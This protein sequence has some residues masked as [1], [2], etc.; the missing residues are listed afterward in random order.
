MI[1]INGLEINGKDSLG[2]RED[3]SFI[4]RFQWK[5]SDHLKEAIQLL[6][7]SR[8]AALVET[9]SMCQ[10]FSRRFSG[11][12][13]DVEFEKIRMQ[14]ASN[15][16]TPPT[17]LVY[18]AQGAGPAVLERIAEN[19][20]TP[21]TLLNLLSRHPVGAVRAAVG[22]NLN[23]P[24]HVLAR[25][26]VDEDLDVRYRLAENPLLPHDVLLRLTEDCNPYVAFRAVATMSRAVGGR[27]VRGDFSDRKSRSDDQQANG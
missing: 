16:S 8:L 25:L 9:E 22:E 26:V 18:I 6:L 3:L 27:V 19:P 5:T 10:P 23:T 13:D 17:V 4:V 2:R 1:E 20:Q 15:P 24:E 7:S 11:T 21:T 14:I 12:I